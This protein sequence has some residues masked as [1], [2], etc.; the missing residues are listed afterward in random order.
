MSIT[1]LV[2]SEGFK[3]IS[4]KVEKMGSVVLSVGLI[5]H[6]FKIAQSNNFLSIGFS[7]L[8]LIYFFK[9]FSKTNVNVKIVSIIFNKVYGYSLAMSLVTVMFTL[10]KWPISES[11]LFFSFILLLLATYLSIMKKKE[12]KQI[13][14][15]KL[16]FI[17]LFIATALVVYAYLSK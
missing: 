2:E 6:F 9:A 1:S 13:S 4:S 12:E 8:A 17:R 10:E 7:S 3:K 14:F 16:H 11:S 15:D 5:M